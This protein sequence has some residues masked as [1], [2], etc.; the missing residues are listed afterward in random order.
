MITPKQLLVVVTLALLLV[1]GLLPAGCAC[2]PGQ[3]R[4]PIPAPSAY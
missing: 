4:P 1:A 2:G 3:C